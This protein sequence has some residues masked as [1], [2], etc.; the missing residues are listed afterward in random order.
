MG[1][2]TSISS[3]KVV[4]FRSLVTRC[5][6]ASMTSRLKSAARLCWYGL[7]IPPPDKKS[8]YTSMLPA[9]SQMF[10]PLNNLPVQVS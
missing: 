2:A 7:P 4:L 6:P 3:K 1:R 9:F 10:W 5:R 8:A